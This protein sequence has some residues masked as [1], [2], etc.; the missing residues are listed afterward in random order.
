MKKDNQVRPNNRKYW[1][2]ISEGKVIIVPNIL[3]EGKKKIRTKQT[4]R[5][6]QVIRPKGRLLR[7]NL[8]LIPYNFQ[9]MIDELPIKPIFTKKI[10]W[11]FVS[12][13]YFVNWLISKKEI[14][15]TYTVI[16]WLIYRKRDFVWLL[17]NYQPLLFW[18]S[19]PYW[20]VSWHINQEFSLIFAS[21]AL[22]AVLNIF[23]YRPAY[24]SYN[25]CYFISTNA[26]TFVC[27]L[28]CC[29]LP[30][31]EKLTYHSQGML[32]CQFCSYFS[33]DCAP[34]LVSCADMKIS[35]SKSL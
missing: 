23:P 14:Y 18:L 10:V 2:G 28:R 8:A 6:A 17:Q 32:D 21:D 35:I 30:L 31:S 7:C 5:I 24:I 15:W 1:Y 34:I 3:K 29:G 25:W 4:E 19:S 12:L 13:K 11:L 26:S 20:Y 16:I 9:R 22:R 33:L 27:Y